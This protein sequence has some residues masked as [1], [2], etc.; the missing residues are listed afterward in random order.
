MTRT[1]TTVVDARSEESAEQK[2]DLKIDFN[3][4]DTTDIQVEELDD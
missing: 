4:A 1:Q 3:G 2:G